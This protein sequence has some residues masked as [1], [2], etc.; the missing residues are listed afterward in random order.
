[1]TKANGERLKAYKGRMSAAGFRRLSCW[2]HPDL[3]D[4][5][6]RERRPG[7]CRGR[8]L[9]RLLLGQARARPSYWSAHD[10]RTN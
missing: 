6:E 10:K 5:L 8:T 9:E 4:E 2:L 1:M 3:L 7:E